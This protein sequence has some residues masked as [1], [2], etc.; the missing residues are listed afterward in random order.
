MIP[1]T[2]K[3]ISPEVS[4][5]RSSWGPLSAAGSFAVPVFA[6]LIGY[7]IFVICFFCPRSP[8]MEEVVVFNAVYTYAHGGQMAFPVYG[9]DYAHSFGIHPHL[10]Y[11]ILGLLLRSGLT[12]YAAE[13]TAIFA[14]AAVAIWLVVRGHFPDAVRL[15]FLTGL[16]GTIVLA[17]MYLPDEA[18]GVRPELHVTI[19]WFAGL[20]ALESARLDNWH[21]PTM[22]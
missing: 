5:A 9:A 8:G 19:A 10:H 22:C 4:A 12:L 2:E 20:V 16:Y 17:V 13:G 6:V 11:A 1:S 7:L 14:F 18:V 15:G 21:L 3:T